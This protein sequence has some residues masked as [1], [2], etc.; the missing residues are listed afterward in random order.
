MKKSFI[1][2]VIVLI[3]FAGACNNQTQNRLSQ[4][5]TTQYLQKGKEIT[6]SSFKALSSEL[7]AALARGGIEEAIAYCN[8]EAMPITDSLS[9]AYDVKI[10]RTSLQARNPGNKPT[11]EEKEILE[12]YME[13]HKQGDTLRPA[14]HRI[15][16]DKV[17]FTAPIMVQPLCL[18]CHG[19]IGKSLQEKN[20]EIIRKH[21]PEDQATGYQMG[22]FRGMWSIEF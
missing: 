14:V 5:E 22:D 17:L 15:G 13:L 16:K 8:I 3:V 2:F 1:Y 11:E 21:Y 18:N 4:E 19:E 20:Y 12:G 7:K 6:Q 9:E 10:R